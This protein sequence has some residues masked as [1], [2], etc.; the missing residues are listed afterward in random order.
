MVD[1]P[2]A[3]ASSAVKVDPIAN[4]A[5]GPGDG[6]GGATVAGIASGWQLRADSLVV[7]RGALL[8]A[9]LLVWQI[10]AAA[11]DNEAFPTV[12]HFAVAVGEVARTSAYWVSL[13]QTLA[14]WAIGLSAAVLVGV[15]IGLLIGLNTVVDHA[16]RVTVAALQAIPSI[17]LVPLLV[18]IYGTTLQMKI[19]LVFIAAS[20]PLLMQSS[21]GARE[22]DHVAKETA[23]SYRLTRIDQARYLYLPSA[24]AFVAT[25]LRIAATIALL[26]TIG[27]EI[28][29]SAPGIGLQIQLGESNGQPDRAFVYFVTAS[30]LGLLIA[31]AFRRIERLA[32]FWH[33]A[34][35]ARQGR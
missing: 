18:L 8:I 13:G 33:P 7:R 30:L 1:R 22:V 28:V 14:A 34:H 27:S 6:G 35:R 25:G 26:V 2:E 31:T 15:P 23:R 4:H 11:I 10:A 5:A 19:I 20:W 32:L 16:T 21:Y 24:S 29:T 12:T 3:R 17:V 9:S